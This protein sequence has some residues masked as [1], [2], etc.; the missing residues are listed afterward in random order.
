MPTA[1]DVYV[2]A[3]VARCDALRSAGQP[4]VD[5]PGVVGLRP[6]AEHPVARLLIT[7]DRAHDAVAA[8]LPHAKAGSINVLAAASRCA[9]LVRALDW[10]TEETTALGL[11]DLRMLPDVPPPDGLNVRPVRRLPDDPPDGVPL[12]DAVAAA[13]AAFPAI[14]DP[15]AFADHLREW[16]P[17]T[18]LF[19]ATDAEGVVRATSGSGTFGA[20]ASVMFVNTDA[21]WR[22]RG[23]ARAMTAV[24]LYAAGEQGARHAALDATAAGVSIYRRLGFAVVGPTIRVRRRLTP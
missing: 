6:S 1:L 12:E 5:E 19:A 21:G 16:P 15:K 13:V 14:G 9:E 11:R 2:A 18:R 23:I 8:M 7:D 17:S 20:T 4:V 22:G 24:A 10:R 3:F